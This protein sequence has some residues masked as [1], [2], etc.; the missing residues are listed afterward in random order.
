MKV[1]FIAYSFPPEKGSGTF[2]SFYFAKYL[3]KKVKSIKIYTSMPKGELDYSLPVEEIQGFDNIVVDQDSDKR[4]I[5]FL[6][7]YRLVTL[8]NFI[9]PF[10]LWHESAC[11]AR[12]V[13]KEFCRNYEPGG[14]DIIYSTT[15]P[16]SAALTAYKINKKYGVPYVV[17][18][19]D[20]FLENP[21]H[22]WSSLFH[23]KLMTYMESKVLK[24]AKKVIVTCPTY[25]E[26]L[27]SKYRF[28]KGNVEVIYNGFDGEVEDL[29]PMQKREKVKVVY[30][31]M[32]SDWD[33]KLNKRRD[34]WYSRPY[35]KAFFNMESRS[36][37]SLIN[38]IANSKDVDTLKNRLD[39]QIYGN[40]SIPIT[41]KLIKK[42]NLGGIFSIN[43][44]VS[45]KEVLNAQK[46]ADYLLLILENPLLVERNFFIAGKIFDFIKLKKQAVVVGRKN[47]AT[48]ILN[49]LGL[50]KSR[51]N[52]SAEEISDDII[53]WLDEEAINI[54]YSVDVE[55]YKR[56]NQ[57]DLLYQILKQ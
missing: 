49:S 27:Q 26:Y 31:G 44:N 20:P 48:E 14:V 32:L 57:A 54:D 22:I 42:N 8:F 35:S 43:G 19:R 18:L 47:D 12:S 24:K 6:K 46:E 21:Y 17:D 4:L 52:N 9:F 25:S 1:A 55:K 40:G 37:Y 39:I 29:T 30:A 36:L 45:Y 10:Y 7:K 53:Q 15:N 5:E 50:L 2:R 3:S 56:K 23:F 33:G 11:W 41:E 51:I 38:G 16:F 34:K 28:L 13:Y